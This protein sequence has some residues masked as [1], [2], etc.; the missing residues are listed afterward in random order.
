MCEV[1][2]YKSCPS[3]DSEDSEVEVIMFDA[4]VKELNRVWLGLDSQCWSLRCPPLF[5]MCLL[6]GPTWGFACQCLS[7]PTVLH[8]VF[9]SVATLTM[10]GGVCVCVVYRFHN[11][12]PIPS[13][14]PKMPLKDTLPPRLLRKYPGFGCS[15]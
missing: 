7:R 9:S 10:D 2:Q 5:L 14:K 11:P 1:L 15:A 13:K 8:H 12:F 4:S 3:E 6:N